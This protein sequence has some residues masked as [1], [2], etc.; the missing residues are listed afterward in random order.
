MSINKRRFKK[1]NP[2]PVSGVVAKLGT[3]YYFVIKHRP[4]VPGIYIPLTKDRAIEISTTLGIDVVT[5]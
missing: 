2:P 3:R 5:K 1:G 4:R